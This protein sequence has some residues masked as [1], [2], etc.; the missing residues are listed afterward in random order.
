MADSSYQ[1]GSVGE[2]EVQCEPLNVLTLTPLFQKSV[3]IA[4]SMFHGTRFKQG[5]KERKMIFSRP[6]TCN[7]G[8][9]TPHIMLKKKSLDS[10]IVNL[11]KSKMDGYKIVKY[12]DEGGFGQV[13]LAQIRATKQVSTCDSRIRSIFS[14]GDKLV[15]IKTI[16]KRTADYKKKIE[17]LREEA[18]ILSTLDHVHIV[19]LMEDDQDRPVDY[20]VLKYCAEDDLRA[21]IEGAKQST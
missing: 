20:F 11:L 13:V 16:K 10:V 5:T 3:T 1:Q 2:P 15:A 21:A 18:A 4:T 12:L 7:N 9:H 14:A 8:T 17:L 6:R 19:C